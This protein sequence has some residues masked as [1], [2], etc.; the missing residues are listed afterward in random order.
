MTTPANH[1]RRDSVPHLDLLSVVYVGRADRTFDDVFTL[2][3]LV[4][5]DVTRVAAS[6]TERQGVLRLVGIEGD[7]TK[8]VASFH[9]MF[10]PYFARGQLTL[11][12]R[13]DSADLLELMV[14]VGAT[15][16]GKVLGVIGAHGGAG[17]SS[18]AAWLGRL[19]SDDETVALV[20]LD[21]ASVG[22]DFMLAIQREPG[23]RWPDLSGQGAL[24]PGRLGGALPSWHGVRVL[25]ADDR[26]GA[27]LVG[28]GAVRAISA[29]SQVHSWTILD[30]PP[31]GAVAG[32][33]EN[34]WIEWCDHLLLVTASDSVSLARARVK[35]A[36][37]GQVAPLTVVAMGVK[38]KAEAAHVAEVIGVDSVVPVRRLRGIEGDVNHGLAPGDRSRS[39]TSRD[40]RALTRHCLDVVA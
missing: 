20:D 39:D 35:A 8:V 14:A 13:D 3:E 10:A 38:S 27:P 6:E 9:P 23:R 29:L 24:L 11:D 31:S 37:L 1:S 15:M 7:P 32:T 26:G 33:R 34:R 21:P 16:R 5:V 4:G 12:V 30:L 17:T 19:L 22:L 18:L 25:S 40:V 28:D 36:A 2:A